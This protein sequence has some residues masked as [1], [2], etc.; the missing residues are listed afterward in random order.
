MSGNTVRICGGGQG[1]IGGGI[2]GERLLCGIGGSGGRGTSGGSRSVSGPPY[3]RGWHFC[4]NPRG[5]NRACC[6][7]RKDLSLTVKVNATR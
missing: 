5:Y 4:R 2:S 1:S 3:L 6:P 7:E